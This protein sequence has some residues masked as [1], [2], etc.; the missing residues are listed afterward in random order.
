MKRVTG[1]G[2][3]FFKAKDAPSLQ[4]WYKRPPAAMSKSGAR[5][6]SFDRTRGP[7]GWRGKNPPSLPPQKNHYVP[8][9]PPFL[10]SSQ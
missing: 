9:F 6:P 10:L 2:G 8:T 5:G 1:I 7:G 3:I 4:A